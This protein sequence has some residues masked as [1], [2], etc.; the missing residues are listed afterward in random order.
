MLYNFRTEWP[1]PS[2]GRS[3]LAAAAAQAQLASYAQTRPYVSCILLLPPVQQSD[4][5][6]MA[7]LPPSLELVGYGLVPASD[8]L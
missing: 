2:A 3:G 1:F 7:A 8:V 5:S 6:L 4:S